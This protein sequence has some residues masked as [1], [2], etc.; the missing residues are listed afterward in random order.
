MSTQ[1]ARNTSADDPTGGAPAAD[2]RL[3]AMGR[4]LDELLL[5]VAPFVKLFN[6]AADREDKPMLTNGTTEAVIANKDL[7]RLAYAADDAAT[8]QSTQTAPAAAALPD[9]HGCNACSHPT[10]ARFN[11]PR[12]VECGAMAHNA[13][14]RQHQVERQQRDA[15]NVFTGPAAPG[16]P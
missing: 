4:R 5:A 8:I 11:G 1:L 3:L 2:L 6:Q 7:R 12:S 13:C 15:S 16:M 10:C 9:P 14:V